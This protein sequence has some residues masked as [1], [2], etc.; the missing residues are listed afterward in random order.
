MVKPGAATPPAF[1]LR[2]R[3]SSTTTSCPSATSA[4]GSASTTSAKPPVFENGSPSDATKSIFMPLRPG[5]TVLKGSAVVKRT[6][7]DLCR[8]AQLLV[9]FRAVSPQKLGQHFLTDAAWRE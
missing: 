6:P 3:G 8:S 9:H 5:P 1:V 4:L 7:C 2:Y